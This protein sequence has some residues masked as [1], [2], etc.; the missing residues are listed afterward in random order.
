MKCNTM[1]YYPVQN[2]TGEKITSWLEKN[3]LIL[4]LRIGCCWQEV[5]LLW[6]SGEQL[7]SFWAEVWHSCDRC[8]CPTKSSL[9]PSPA[10]TV[11]QLLSPCWH[12]SEHA[13][14]TLS[15]GSVS[16]LSG[17][18]RMLG[19]SEACV[20]VIT[21]QALPISPSIQWGLVLLT[22]CPSQSTALWPLQ[23]LPFKMTSSLLVLWTPSES[24]EGQADHLCHHVW[25]YCR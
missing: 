9:A 11:V 15:L 2:G 24:S 12:T 23:S 4:L 25:L 16:V 13:R 7:E 6:Y 10:V 3:V 18:S 5:C 1:L 8:S 20:E 22:P 19:L 21:T 17:V 14:D